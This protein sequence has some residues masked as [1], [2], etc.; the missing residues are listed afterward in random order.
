MVSAGESR[1]WPR[2]GQ[3]QYESSP[4]LPA[5]A[6]AG[7][8]GRDGPGL[9]RADAGHGRSSR[10]VSAD[11]RVHV[12]AA[13]NAGPR[14]AV[15][16][17]QIE[18][19]TLLPPSTI[20][21]LLTNIDGAYGTNVSLDGIRAAVTELRQ[22]YMARGFVTVDVTL[23]PQRLT[24]ATVKIQVTEGRLVAIDVKGNRYFSSNNVMRAL[25]SL[26]TNMILIAQIFQAELNRANADQD[27]Q[28]SPVIEPGPDPG[29]SDLTLN[30]QDRLPIHGKIDLDNQSSPGTPPLRVNASAV[31]R[32]PL[33]G[34]K[35]RLAFNMAFPPRNTRRR[36]SGIFTT[37]RW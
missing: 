26:H 35:T 6:S 18:G 28:I 37:S 20:A 12:V 1:A 33:A 24:N 36:P 23:P 4:G 17:Y 7:H 16:K 8:S 13:T 14:F 21:T 10:P 32:Q 22:A 34:S 9:H 2:L 25:P 5:T 15:E 31:D 27:R 3:S 11:T 19:N 29:T 30:V